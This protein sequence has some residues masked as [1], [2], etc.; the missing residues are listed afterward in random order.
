MEVFINSTT[1][2]IETVSQFEEIFKS[3]ENEEFREIWLNSPEG[4]SI[5]ALLNKKIGW[6]MFLRQE[7]DPG[8]SSRN[9]TFPGNEMINYNLS[10]GQV[11]EYPASWAFSESE[12]FD[13]LCY[14]VE[15]KDRTPSIEWHDDSK[16]N[17]F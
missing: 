10:N 3:Y 16:T 12:I 5:C 2:N 11:D 15:H 14:F 13:A 17:N 8:F 4:P 7:G 9:I 6:L 1:H